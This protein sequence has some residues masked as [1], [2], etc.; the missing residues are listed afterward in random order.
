MEHID[1]S[2]LKVTGIGTFRDIDSLSDKRLKDNIQPIENA[3]EKVSNLRGVTYEWINSR[4][5]SMGVVA[6]EVEKEFPTL[7]HGT[8]PKS[9]NYNGLI[10]ALIESVKELKSQNEELVKR[11]EKLEGDK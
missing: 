2:T 5:P 4:K 11:I 3:L 7:I 8:F 9:V 1:A 6:Q 10:G